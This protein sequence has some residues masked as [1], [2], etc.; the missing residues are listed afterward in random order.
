M[1]NSLTVYLV[2]H[3]DGPIQG[4]KPIFRWEQEASVWNLQSVES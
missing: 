2:D 1:S 4:I 3:L